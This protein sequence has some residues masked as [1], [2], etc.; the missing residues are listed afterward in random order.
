MNDMRLIRV[1]L[2]F[3][4]A[5]MLT[6]CSPDY[7]WRRVQPAD[8][9]FA[10]M[11]PARPASMSQQVALDG[12]AIEMTLHGARVDDTSYTVGVLRL[13][14]ETPA[15]RDRVLAALRQSMVANIA[16]TESA[17]DSVQVRTE[18]GSGPQ[19]GRLEGLQIKARGM[20]RKQPAVLTARFV[21]RGDRIWQA[22]VLT[23]EAASQKREHDDSVAQ[24]L[25]GFV[26]IVR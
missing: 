7:D 18:E 17:S 13:P 16:G 9:G 3:V 24:F 15:T 20:M 10:A 11:L 14:D 5:G 25:D 19:I 6:A 12:I 26:L 21:A 4:M 2:A 23:P 1:A 8:G 22:M